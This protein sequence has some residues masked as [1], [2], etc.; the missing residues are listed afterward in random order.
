MNTLLSPIPATPR[1]FS[2]LSLFL[3]TVAATCFIWAPARASMPSITGTYE[4]EGSIIETDSDYAG[5][6]S[7][8]ALFGLELDLA[9][10]SITHADITRVEIEQ[11]D[12]TFTVRTKEANGATEWSGTWERNGGYEPTKDGVKI[13]LR[14][15]RFGDDFFMFTLS[16]MKEGEVLLVEVQR[17]QAGKFG[18]IGKPVGK[19]LFLRIPP[20]S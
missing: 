18:P 3:L 12:R 16:S 20:A 13:L 19:F 10:G 9:A 6:V 17:I 8:R 7:L 11:R 1:R 4:S 14:H 2:R 5:P 15:A